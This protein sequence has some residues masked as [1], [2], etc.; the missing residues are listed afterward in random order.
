MD[1]VRTYLVN[2]PRRRKRLL[3]VAT[4][5]FLVWT[6]LWL[7]FIVRLGIDDMYNPLKVHFWL[8]AC[9][10]VIAVPL[11]IRFGMYRAVM[12]YFGNDALIAIIKAVS[13]SSL[14]L[15]LVVYWYSNHEAVVPRSIIFNYWW[16]SLV[17]IGGL[18]LCM[19]Q[20]FMGD[21][22]TA[23]KHV[24]FTNRDDDLTKVAIY[25]AGVAGNQL[26]AALR[27]GRVMR[28]VAFIDDDSSIADRS[29]AGLQVY[30][31]KHIQQMIDVTGAQEILLAL[32]S[33][34][35]ARRREILNFLEGYPL[36]IRSVPNFTDL[37]SG[38]VKVDD[39]QE[40][41]IA[42]LLGRDAVPAQ[43]DLLE[44]CIKGKTVMV[45]GAGGSIGS[46]L[47][48][49]IFSLGPTALLLFEH[50]EFNLYSIL[51]E[52]EQRSSRE[53]APIR[54]LPILGSIR[55]QEK[56]LD[57]MKTWK[58][59]TVYHAA[60]YKHVPMVEHNIAEGV[61][62]NALGT[63]NT[64]Q[65]ALQSGVSNFVLIST[66]KAVRPT[67]VMGSTKRLAEMTLQA[68][69][70]EVAPVLFNDSAKVSR[71]NKTRFTMV[72]FGNVLGSSGSVIPLFHSQIKS[73]GP[74]T[75]TH[76]KIT[77]YF[78]TIPEAAQLVI[79]AGSMGEG[80]DVFVLDMGEPV[81]IVELAEKMIHLSGLSIRSD[82]NPQGDISIEFTGLRPGEKLY[83]E[84]LI[85]DNVSATSHPMIMSA[86][87]DYL[88]WDLLKVK[89]NELLKA[90][91]ADDY[92]RV[93]QL[94]RET[95]SGYTPDGEIVDWI[96]QQRRL[97]P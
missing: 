31:P 40:V 63:L 6:A 77:R 49:Q 20:Y 58:V 44:R 61:L 68:L 30:K 36:H 85:G 94:L 33:S 14:L 32:P 21:W 4:D 56:L 72:R 62:N 12:R 55:H 29:I 48:R 9:A 43:P 46:E 64:A 17:I 79:Q 69:S 87:E 34:T 26:V 52:L 88:P 41:D 2:L 70:R 66:D 25:G 7:A 80:G 74:L 10:P 90:V 95:V 38:R 23:V 86:K 16:L 89:L 5:I 1:K 59:D 71:V 3:Q 54:L 50:G 92:T 65:A 73:G 39:I 24:P 13:L 81:K 53:S 47:C 75:V 91:E 15:A 45:T 27:M 28:P 78:M 97:E 11:F 84:L 57:V 35:R 82:R 60:A 18:R 19:R 8:F 93:R 83:E 22:F 76:P 42:D 37:A 51:S 96:H 67:N